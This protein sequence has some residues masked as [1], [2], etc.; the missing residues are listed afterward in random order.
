M[1]KHRGLSRLHRNLVEQDLD[2][3]FSENVFDKIVLSH[4]HTARDE[5]DVMLQTRSDLRAQV[6][7]IVTRDPKHNGVSAGAPH[8]R[9]NRIR[10]AVRVLV[11]LWYLL[12]FHKLV[13]GGNYRNAWFLRTH[14]SGFSSTCQQSKIRHADAPPGAEDFVALP[15]LC[16]APQQ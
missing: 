3:K 1:A 12:H 13:A 9:G 16:S 10:V 8:L 15:G 14:H 4:R 6:L 11:G 7:E 5:Q 2:T